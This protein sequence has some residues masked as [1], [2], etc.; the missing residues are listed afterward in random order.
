MAIALDECEIDDEKHT[1]KKKK[2]KTR[3][4]GEDRSWPVFRTVRVR[5]QRTGKR[6][7]SNGS[8]FRRDNDG[9]SCEVATERHR[10]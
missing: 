9:I 4:G 8:R 5:S 1:K 6:C 10:F 7:Q 2:K 3:S